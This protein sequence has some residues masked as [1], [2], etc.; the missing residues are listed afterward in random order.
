ML[1]AFAQRS[2]RARIELQLTSWV[3]NDSHGVATCWL[4]SIASATR[5]ADHFRIKEETVG[6]D[7]KL[8]PP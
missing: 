2:R 6:L 4:D 1:T 5:S 3:T 8:W 7:G